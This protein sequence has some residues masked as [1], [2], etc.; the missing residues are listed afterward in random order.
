MVFFIPPTPTLEYMVNGNNARVFGYE[1]LLF[2]GICYASLYHISLQ[3]NGLDERYNQM[4]QD[5]L[6]KYACEKKAVWDDFLDTCV[7]AY[8]T[9]VHE[10]TAFIQWY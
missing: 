2:T 1:W 8:N 5:M 6:V 9:S 7:Y 4:L 10:T 3:A